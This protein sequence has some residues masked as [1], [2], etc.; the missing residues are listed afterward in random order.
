[1]PSTTVFLFGD[2][3]AEV[4]PSIE[5]LNAHSLSSPN[6]RTFSRRSTDR[7]RAAIAR[8]PAQYRRQFPA[9]FESPLELARWAA[10]SSQ[11]DQTEQDNSSTNSS[12]SSSNLRLRKIS[13]ALSAALLCV[14]QLGHVIV[15]VLCSSLPRLHDD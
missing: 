5:S 12:S 11:Q 13:P 2:Q 8:L 15:Y 1:M 9:S 4:L 14:A 10:S 7:L 3:T 6:L